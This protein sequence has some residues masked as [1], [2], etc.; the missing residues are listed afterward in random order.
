MAR[1]ESVQSVSAIFLIARI[2]LQAL[3][4]IRFCVPKE[5]IQF[6]IELKTGLGIQ[7]QRV[8]KYGNVHKPR[9]TT[10]LLHAVQDLATEDQWKELISFLIQKIP[11]LSPERVSLWEQK[12]FEL[13]QW[14]EWLIFEFAIPVHGLKTLLNINTERRL[15]SQ[16][17]EMAK[18]LINHGHLNGKCTVSV[19]DE[20]AICDSDLCKT[21]AFYALTTHS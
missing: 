11:S 8:L 9:Q 7:F 18:F 4:F 3:N 16:E 2:I 13:V 15:T 14:I 21:H 1:P 5:R 19:C 6:L 17:K 12:E 10:E 20:L